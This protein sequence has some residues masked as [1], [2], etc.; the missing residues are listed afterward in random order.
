MTTAAA[1]RNVTGTRYYNGRKL[2]ECL[3]A[4]KPFV[5]ILRIFGCEAWIRVSQRKKLD[6]IAR[7]GIVLQSSP[8]AN[9]R[10]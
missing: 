8:R 3:T 1:L 6:P 10:V 2:Q 7:R 5:G 4:R 9:D